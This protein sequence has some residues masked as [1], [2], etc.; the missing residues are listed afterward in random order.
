[1]RNSGISRRDYERLSP[2]TKE[3]AVMLFESLKTELRAQGFSL[4]FLDLDGRWKELAA[5]TFLSKSQDDYSRLIRGSKWVRSRNKQDL[6]EKIAELY[7]IVTLTP[8][9]KETHLERWLG[10]P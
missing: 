6:L 1:M 10:G 3:K 4:R 2:E 7:S 5:P 9:E 8:K